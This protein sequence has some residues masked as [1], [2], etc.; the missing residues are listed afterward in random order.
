MSINLLKASIK[1]ANT[2]H[3]ISYI[4]NAY[5]AKRQRGVFLIGMLNT[6]TTNNGRLFIDI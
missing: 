3:T 5:L 4:T 1:H 6:N 2:G